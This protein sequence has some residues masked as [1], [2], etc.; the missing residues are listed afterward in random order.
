MQVCNAGSVACMEKAEMELVTV[1]I[2]SRLEEKTNT[3]DTLGE[4]RRVAAECKCLPACTSIEYEAETSQ[5]D[6]D[7]KALF[8]AFNFPLDEEDNDLIFARVMIFFKEAQ[9]ITSRRSELYGQTDFL[10]NCGGLL[11]LFMG[12]SILSVAEIIYF[13][14]LRCNC[15]KNKRDKDIKKNIEPATTDNVQIK[16]GTTSLIKQYFI[17]YTANSN[18]HGLK[19]IGEKERTTVEKIFWLLMFTCCVVFCAYL[20]QKVWV[21]WNDSPVIV[22]FAETSTPVWQIPYPAVTLCPDAKVIKKIN[23]TT[24]DYLIEMDNR[25]E[26][27]HLFE[28]V[29]LICNKNLDELINGRNFSDGNETV[30]NIKK[31]SPTID[32]VILGLMWKDVE[33]IGRSLFSPILTEESYCYTFNTIDADQL[34]RIENLNTDYKYLESSN[35]SQ[36]WTLENGYLP[37]TPLETYPHRGLGYGEN[38][39]LV[40]LLSAPKKKTVKFCD[41]ETKGFKILLH[42]P[43]EFPRISQQYFR[44]PLDQDVVVAV[45]PKMMTTSEGLKAYDSTRRQCYFSNDR[46]LKFFKVYTQTNCETECLTNFTYARCGCVHFGMPHGPEMRVCSIGKR[47]CMN[48]ARK[49]LVRIQIQNNLEDAMHAD[50]TIGE[51]RRVATNCKCL[52]ACTSID[53]EVEISQSDFNYEDIYSF[54]KFEEEQG[55]FYTQVKIF[56]KEAQFIKVRRSELY[57][58]T[59]FLANCG[60]LLG[61]FLGFSIL[62]VVEILYFLTLRI[63]CLLWRCRQN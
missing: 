6:F 22:S 28:D 27:A 17:D 7:Y 13:L 40:L 61:L 49:E 3:N 15:F 41:G 59:D 50:D 44:V 33:D 42:N 57:G 32:D 10:A 53:Y 46:Y 52:P 48:D 5:A 63:C 23:Y 8:R 54:F 9:F 11:G 37:N 39:G 1:E 36:T 43:A 16:R 31:V 35:K 38:A 34:L 30:E 29:A 60:G 18:L 25:T 24:F 51:A 62:S 55:T 45:K 14:T 19:Y 12:F 2:Q 21:K 56:F 4:A 26:E 20:I 47:S 58:H